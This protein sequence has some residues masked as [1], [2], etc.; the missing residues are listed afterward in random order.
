MRGNYQ[1][2][3]RIEELPDLQ[4]VEPIQQSV[5]QPE[6][7]MSQGEVHPKLQRFIRGNAHGMPTTN[8]PIEYYE[9]DTGNFQSEDDAYSG[10]PPG[11]FE[12][13]RGYKP[14]QVPSIVSPPIMEPYEPDHSHY[15]CR[16]LYG[17]VKECDIC[18]RFYKN[19]NT[20]YLVI[21]AILL[22]ACALLAKKVMNV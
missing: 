20:L 22:V 1:K 3:T 12:L 16:D 18:K 13:T 11:G 6:Y 9:Q 8:L 2:F 10:I 7:A 19:D 21:I 17:H 14:K 4:Q 15:N 5:A